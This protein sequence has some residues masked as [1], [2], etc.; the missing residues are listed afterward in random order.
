[1]LVLT[2]APSKGLS[3]TETVP[4]FR[5]S[6]PSDITVPLTNSFSPTT[7]SSLFTVA[8]M[9]IIAARTWMF[10]DISVA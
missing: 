3:D 2:A 5:G 9:P 8:V 4:T 1:M 6:P 10:R 7:N